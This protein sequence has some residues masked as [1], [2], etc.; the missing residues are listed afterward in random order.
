MNEKKNEIDIGRAIGAPFKDKDWFKKSLVI[1]LLTLI[2]FAGWFNLSGWT[3]A[4]TERRLAGG[5]DID[6]LPE[7][8]LS[9]I[10]GGWRWFVSG[11]PLMAIMML[12]LMVGGGGAA[13]IGITAGKH[14][15]EDIAAVI[16]MLL[17]L[18]FIAGAFVVG[19][20][21]PAMS[22]IHVVEGERFAS[23]QFRRIWQVM[24]LGGMQY[25]LLWVAFFVAGL[26][27]QVGMFACYVGLFVSLPLAQAIMAA[28]VADFARVIRPEEPSDPV[29]GGVGGSSGTPFGISS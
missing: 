6:I 25:F 18:G 26:I 13:V 12:V 15:G 21:Q 3:R 8:N 10:S 16:V 17:Y 24:K 22:F 29:E 20:A 28:A 9:Y 14:H 4:I 1:G 2:P 11:I 7:A 5:P 27:A 19:I 23:V